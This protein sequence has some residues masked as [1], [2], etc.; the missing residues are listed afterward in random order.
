MRNNPNIHQEGA[1]LWYVYN[2]VLYSCKYQRERI[3]Y[4]AMQWSQEN[5][6]KRQVEKS[7]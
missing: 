4:I 7:V 2:R 1:K 5:K 6:Y 3:S